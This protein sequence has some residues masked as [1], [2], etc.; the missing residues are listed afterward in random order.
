[1]HDITILNNIFLAFDGYF[2]VFSASSFCFKLFIV[3][4]INY[5]FLDKSSLEV[6]V[7]HPC[8]LWSFPTFANG[9]CANFLYA[10]SKVGDQVE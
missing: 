2:T 4:D 9:P 6:G 5:F 1:M 10:C 3:S 7:N 8:S